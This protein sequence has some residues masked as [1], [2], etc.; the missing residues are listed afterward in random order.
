VKRK[1]E[2]LH[3]LSLLVDKT[4]SERGYSSTCRLITRVAHTLS[5]IYPLNSQFI[6]TE[7]WEGEDLNNNHLRF[8]GQQYESKDV[9]LDWHVPSMEEI[10]LV[11]EI[12]D[13]IVAPALDKVEHILSAA[14]WDEAAR[15]DFCRFLHVARSIWSGLSTFILEQEKECPNPCL[16]Q[17]T[18][19]AGLGMVK[20]SV[21]SGFVLTNPT[22]ARFQ[23][24]LQHKSRFGQLAQRAASVL[25]RAEGEDHI[26]AI[27]GALKAIDVY[28]LEYGMSRGA[29]DSLQ[30]SYRQSR[31][32]NRVWYN[33][34][35]NSRLVFS[36]RAQVYHYG[37]VYAQTLYRVR[38]AL[39]DELL[40]ELVEASLSHYTRVR[41]YAQAILHNASTYYVRC[42]RF[43]L[44][45][46]LKVVRTA[47]KPDRKKGALYIL[48][49]K[50]MA[51]NALSEHHYSEYLTTLLGCQ[52]EEKP[53]IQKIVNDLSSDCL[54]HLQEEF[55]NTSAYTPEISSLEA[56][57]TQL[58]NV[59][60]IDQDLL[61]EAEVK[62]VNRL[63]TRRAFHEGAIESIL[64]L[65]DKP[66]T[67][68]RYVLIAA[69]FLG[70]LCRRDEAP[71]QDMMRFF[72][73]H[74]LNPQPSIRKIVQ[75]AL[76]KS[77]TFVKLRTF[78][79]TPAELWSE[80]TRNPLHCWIPFTSEE[81][82]LRDISDSS[83]Q[84]NGIFIDKIETG[85]LTWSKSIRG[86]TSVTGSECPFSWDEPSRPALT[87]V[88]E[89][90]LQ[91]D[92]FSQLADL[93]GQ[94]SSVEI[95]TLELRTRNID[96]VKSLVKT[97][98]DLLPSILSTIDPLLNDSDKFKQ[99]AGVEL[100]AGLLRG[101]KHYPL[102]SSEYVWTW[103]IERLNRV[104]P[105][106]KPDT[107]SIWEYLFSLQL[108][109]RDPERNRPLVDWILSRPLE[110][111]G[112]SV[113]EM[114]K[115][116]SIFGI[117]VDSLGI[118]FSP[119]SDKYAPTL[120]QNLN[121]A[122]AEVRGHI[123]HVLTFLVRNAWRPTYSS[124]CALL[125][126]CVKSQDPL[127]L[128]HISYHHEV[129]TVL[130]EFA[131]WRE[132]RLPPPR[133]TQSEYDK[134]GLAILTWTWLLAY[135]PQASLVFPYAV[136]LM[137]EIL[138]MTNI[139]DNPELQALSSGV[140]YVL[141]SVATPK[142]YVGVIFD[143]LVDAITTSNSWRTRRYAL[144]VVLAFY[145]RNLLMVP[146][147]T[148]S[149]LTKVLVD[150]LRDENIEVRE[151]AAKV[152]SGVVRCS[153]RNS[154]LSLKSS[155]LESAN[156]T[157][158][159]SRRD[160]GYADALR[161]LH[162]AILGLCSLIESF[163]YSPVEPWMPSLTEVLANHS[164]DPP[165]IS[166]AIRKCASEFKKTH[167]DTWHKDQLA[168]DEDQLQNLSSMLVGT[169]YYA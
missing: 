142:Q 146:P 27:I 150:C 20:L 135:S 62:H 99:R 157:R 32:T 28:L 10:D 41:R 30:K 52:G 67:H 48:A 31:D 25:S 12:L 128:C 47:S 126:A 72:I 55:I 9:K 5:G 45:G 141:S 40:R 107:M 144:P 106:I 4:R 94:E 139:Q 18:E 85:F 83:R 50:V 120:F 1:T 73:Q 88:H 155:F 59:F 124:T 19:C 160:P 38:S 60:S 43:V 3:L 102:A 167:Q 138:R 26:D 163:P 36:K 6:N 123:S 57:M 74:T 112:D 56:V 140:L 51:A 90:I 71:S 2:I 131:R 35:H 137:P 37:R 114:V 92:F 151:M 49:N 34:K 132:E 22:D 33:D 154:I 100:L 153:Q 101:I 81:Q 77:L 96:L 42:A 159:P 121:T 169:S 64:K 165:P 29:F 11:M 134:R 119:M 117:L 91:N 130:T 147:E 39:D 129:T 148:I 84:T 110:F 118:R 95:S 116:A 156:N 76:C 44:P 79:T 93:W 23:K 89:T 8:W 61:A 136:I 143:H 7:Q 21:K 108:V 63:R 97:Y 166:T 127:K 113:F 161:E 86:Y 80:E 58:E 14:I 152:L 98:H 111:H 158:L 162:S 54:P 109:N 103:T 145:F 149:K 13:K 46:V 168:F 75:K 53:S 87:V 133:V 82:I 16:Y 68:W 122:Y 65:A 24:A 125:E 70:H 104:F 17:E 164:T 66:G 15:N 69:R 115:T 78:T 105:Q